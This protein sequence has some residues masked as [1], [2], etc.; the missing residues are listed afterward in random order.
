MAE[1][2]VTWY[3]DNRYIFKLNDALH[4]VREQ[5]KR[6]FVYNWCAERRNTFQG[7]F[8]HYHRLKSDD[9][10]SSFLYSRL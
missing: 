8:F 2:F 1:K 3:I 7:I 9:F 5:V 6:H 4:Q 10:I